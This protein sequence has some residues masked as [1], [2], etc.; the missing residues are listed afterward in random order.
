MDTLSGQKDLVLAPYGEH[1][2]QMQRFANRELLSARNVDNVR[3]RHIE[4]VVDGLVDRRWPQWA[5]PESL[6]RPAGPDRP[7]QCHP[8]VPQHFRPAG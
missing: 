7:H 5:T 1:W 8:D 3:E 6:S 2:R 4:E